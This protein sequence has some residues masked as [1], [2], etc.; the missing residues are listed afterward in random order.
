MWAGARQVAA[1]PA[2]RI[3]AAGRPRVERLVVRQQRVERLRQYDAALPP[4]NIT[5]RATNFSKR[6]TT[7]THSTLTRKLLGSNQSPAR[8][9][10]LGGFTTIAKITIRRSRLCNNR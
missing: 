2:A 9:I 5:R 7:M 8:T 3:P 6:Q 10:T 4:N 1:L